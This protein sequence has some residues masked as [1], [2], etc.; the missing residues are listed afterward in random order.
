[1]KGY[2]FLSFTKNIGT[3]ATEVA[4]SMS[5]KHSQKVL[6]SAKKFTTD[7]TKTASKRTLQK[8]AEATGYLIGKKIAD[9]ITTISISPKEFHSQNI[10]KELHLK[11]N[12]NNIEILKERYKSPEKGQQIIEELKLV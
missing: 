9:K 12:E 7:V 4:K 8:T 5:N 1:M 11:T 10:S 6:D 2:G 3:H